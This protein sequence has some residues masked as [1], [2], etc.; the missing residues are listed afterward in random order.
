MKT[1]RSFDVFDTLLSRRYINSD[2]IWDQMEKS[3]GIQGFASNRKA[4]D[5]GS[6]NLKQIYQTMASA[7]HIPADQVNAFCSDEIAREKE[8]A[9]PIKEN[10]D[11][12]RDGDLLVSDMYMSGEDILNLVRSVGLEKQVTIFQSNG[13]KSTGAFWDRMKGKLDLEYHLG[14]NIHS[15]VQMPL[16]RGFNGVHY[17][18]NLTPRENY[19][20]ENKMTHLGLLIRE[21][22]L[23]NH[24]K[25]FDA[26]FSV[27]NQENLFWLFVACEM[28][29]RK[30]SDKKIV[31]LGRDCQLMHKIYNAYYSVQ[32]YY[33]PFSREVAL[34]Q[35]E[36][37]VQYLKHF[38]TEDSVLVDI[39]STGRT[40]EIICKN[41]PFNVEVMVYSD[42]YWYSEN[43]PS[44]HDSFSSIHR[45]SIIGP[46]SIILEIFNCG[47][48]GKIRHID[49]IEGVPVCRFGETEFPKEVIDVIH[50]PVNDAVALK[51]Y[52]SSITKELADLTIEELEAISAHLMT[53]ISSIPKNFINAL[54]PKDNTYIM[55]EF[56]RK[57]AEYL[58]SIS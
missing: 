21:I 13:D 8:L 56:D 46:T 50:K 6:R 12:V 3:H 5:T 58:N 37:A 45:N 30:Y 20:L 51:A 38:T 28:L 39:S 14:D 52:Y 43:K 16:S 2:I 49:I 53:S 1:I 19:L 31:F 35:T 18:N 57:E 10:I 29:H 27:A 26:L 7:N 17:P 23:R 24:E 15:D 48:H 32:S 55:D 42:L 34:N 36:E 4:A 11:R 47:D 44:I 22:R 33:L 41:H 25:D 54:N 40:W 9:F